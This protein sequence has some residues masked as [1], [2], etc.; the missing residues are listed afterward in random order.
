MITIFWTK[1]VS[2]SPEKKQCTKK[3]ELMNHYCSILYSNVY[4]TDTIWKSW[5]NSGHI[6]DLHCMP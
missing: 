1:W 4:F 6:E 3:I 2:S 5:M